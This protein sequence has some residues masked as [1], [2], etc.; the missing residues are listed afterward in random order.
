QAGV[1]VADVRGEGIE[2]W[3]STE[4]SSGS[5]KVLRVNFSSRVLGQ[6]KIEVQLGQALKNLPAQVVVEPLRV[7]G[8][9]TE[10]AEIGAASAA[11]IRLKTAEL[12][13]LR[14]IPISKLSAHADESL[15]YTADQPDWKLTMA[16]EHLSARVVAEIFNLVT[17]G[18]GI[19]GGSATIRYGL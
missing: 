17:I 2:D 11:G 16:S 6:R 1:V 4:G 19:V 3:K 15:A 9:I 14:E 8:P 5:S 10:R 7:A 12:S 13:G 18:D